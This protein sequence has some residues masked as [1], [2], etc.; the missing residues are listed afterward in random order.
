MKPKMKTDFLVFH[1]M[2]HKL[3]LAIRDVIKLVTDAQYTHFLRSP[4]NQNK[5]KSIAAALHVHLLK[6]CRACDIRWVASSYRSVHA[7]WES[8]QG[9]VNDF[10][11]CSTDTSRGAPNSPTDLSR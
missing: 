5:L 7:V 1:C 4:I 8:Y 11:L 6:V 3:E 2:A 10:Q 9:L